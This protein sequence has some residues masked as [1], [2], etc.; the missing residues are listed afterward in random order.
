MSATEAEG[1]EPAIQR[2]VYD[3]FVY[4]DGAELWDRLHQAHRR[5][6]ALASVTPA[7]HQIQGSTWTA[8][9]VAAH[10][11]TV[12]RRYTQRD[13]SN[14]EGL[15]RDAA[16]LTTL[17]RVQLAEFKDLSVGEVVDLMWQELAD[18]EQRVPRSTD[19]HQT[20][21]FHGGERVDVAGLLGILIGEFLVHGRDVARSRGKSW[22]IGSRNAALALNGMVQAA[23]GF[24]SPYASGDVK[25]EIRTPQSNP[26]ILDLSDGNLDSRLARRRESVDVKIFVR[27]E[28]L[29]LLQLGRIGLLR[30][31]G[32]GSA[33]VGGR[34]PWRITRLGSSFET[35]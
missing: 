19:L 14:A 17:N 34:R 11:L 5:F 35:P 10:L 18:L 24:V 31:S 3:E 15:S 23:P 6:A 29:L 21:P 26:W 22:E 32:L 2:R 9:E 4:T 20:Y 7:K 16:G 28:P 12:L 13:L 27:S 33:V 1:P 8:G 25:M 30:M